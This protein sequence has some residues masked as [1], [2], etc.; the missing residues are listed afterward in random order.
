LKQGFSPPDVAQA[1]RQ[2]R[3][4]KKLPIYIFGGTR[5]PVGSNVEQ[6]LE[7][8]RAAGLENLQHHFYPNGRHESLNEVNRYE[9]T[10]DLIRWLN[11]VVA[12]NP[13]SSST[14][15]VAR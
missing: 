13:T 2:A 9:V 6:F 10:R 14:V 3:I 4:P 11:S 1:S 15:S 12:H 5:D 7:A 8:Y